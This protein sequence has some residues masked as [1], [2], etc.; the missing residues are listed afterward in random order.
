MV[1]AKLLYRDRNGNTLWERRLKKY[2]GTGVQMFAKNAQGRLVTE[3]DLREIS[4][5]AGIKLQKLKKRVPY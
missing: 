1:K 5:R 3:E 4:K 2:H